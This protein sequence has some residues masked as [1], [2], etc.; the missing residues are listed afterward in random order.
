MVQH[1]LAENQLIPYAKIQN[2]AGVGILPRQANFT[3]MANDMNFPSIVSP[4][5]D[6][7]HLGLSGGLVGAGI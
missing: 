4:H 5:W 3:S 7:V 6:K 2:R 1:I